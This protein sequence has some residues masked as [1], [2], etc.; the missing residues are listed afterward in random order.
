MH[1]TLSNKDLSA[2]DAPM[3]M[4]DVSETVMFGRCHV[5]LPQ[6]D[7]LLAEEKA[8]QSDVALMGALCHVSLRAVP[9]AL[10]ASFER[11]SRDHGGHARPPLCAH[12]G[13]ATQG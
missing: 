10:H 7:I 11:L 9:L 1:A 4:E 5:L 13:P 12:P 3:Q 6:Q 8:A 2:S